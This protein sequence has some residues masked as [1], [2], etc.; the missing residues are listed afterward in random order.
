MAVIRFYCLKIIFGQFICDVI[1]MTFID[2]FVFFRG[3]ILY[4]YLWQAT[5]DKNIDLR[6]SS[7]FI[8]LFQSNTQRSKFGSNVSKVLQHYMLWL[9]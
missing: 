5:K 7:S 4:M 9:H 8:E 2:V 1:D 3:D 6:C